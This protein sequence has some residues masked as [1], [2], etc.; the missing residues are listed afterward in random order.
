MVDHVSRQRRSAMMGAVR[1]KHTAPEVIVRK[2][3]HR[4]GLRFRLHVQNLPGRPD[5][6]LPRW[7][8]V[9]FINGCFWHRHRGC[10]R[11]TVPKS[12]SIFWSEKF[13]ANIKRDNRNYALL[14]RLG[15]RVVVIW[16]CQVPTI[17]RAL[18]LLKPVF[19]SK[20]R[21]KSKIKS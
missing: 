16:Q 1:G 21:P 20:K 12:N 7:K 17:E 11:T 6:V 15:W 9:V 19:I 2:A 10:K 5:M 4:S 14:K 18:A 13:A 8:T 3:A